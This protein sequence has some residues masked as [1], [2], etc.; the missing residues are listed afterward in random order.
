MRALMS[1]EYFKLAAFATLIAPVAVTAAPPLT[2]DDPGIL[3]RGQMEIILLVEGER[4]SERRIWQLPALDFSMGI[5][6]NVQ[7]AAVLPRTVSDPRGQSSRSGPGVGELGI[8]WRFV[9]RDSV[10]LAIAPVMAFNLGDASVDRGVVEE[11]RA[12]S[13]PLV[14]EWSLETWRLGAEFGYV[15]EREGA[16]EL[17]WGLSAIRPLG[18]RIEVLA[19]IT[20]GPDRK[21]ADHGSSVRLGIDVAIR[22]G[23]RL[24]FALGTGL[25]DE[26]DS[27]DLDG[28]LG[29]KWIR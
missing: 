25:E 3:D 2:F 12:L 10:A 4:T 18:E 24:L 9:D 27:I 23:L 14:F 21:F 11:T 6:D 13:V 17:S 22:D 28:Y 15:F 29:I 26:P 8:K 1:I 5:S 16:D 19:A 7:V 20:G